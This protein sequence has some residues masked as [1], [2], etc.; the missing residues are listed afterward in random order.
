[1]KRKGTGNRKEER[2]TNRGERSPV[3][4]DR[5]LAVLQYFTEILQYSTFTLQYFYSTFTVLPKTK[6]LQWPDILLYIFSWDTHK[7]TSVQLGPTWGS[8]PSRGSHGAEQQLFS[9]VPKRFQETRWTSPSNSK[10]RTWDSQIITFCL[11][12]VWKETEGTIYWFM[13]AL[14]IPGEQLEWRH[15]TGLMETTYF[16]N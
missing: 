14:R 10:T 2:R 11:E 3:C 15:Q 5:V 4:P 1:M 7:A 13:K 16:G 8:G 12:T 9:S 6:I